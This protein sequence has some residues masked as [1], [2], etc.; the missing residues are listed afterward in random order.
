MLWYENLIINISQT[1]LKYA[2][3]YSNG[4][5]GSSLPESDATPDRLVRLLQYLQ[6]CSGAPSAGR[7]MRQ[8]AIRIIVLA[9]WP[10]GDGLA[11][12]NING[13]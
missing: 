7:N 11:N 3:I 10:V 8:Q 6:Y 1:F 9:H 12:R 5:V 13:G 4:D 2:Q